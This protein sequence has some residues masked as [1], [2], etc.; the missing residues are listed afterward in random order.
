MGQSIAAVGCPVFQLS[1]QFFGN[2]AKALLPQG[3]ENNQLVQ[4]AHQLGPEEAFGLGNGLSG[5]LFKDRFCPRGKA[6]GCT[7]PR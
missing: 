7:L 1:Q 4:T 5:L 2:G 6:Q 3:A